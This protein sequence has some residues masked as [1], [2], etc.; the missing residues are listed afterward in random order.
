LRPLLFFKDALPAADEG[1]MAIDTASLTDE[2]RVPLSSR[3]VSLSTAAWLV[4]LIALSAVLRAIAAFSHATPRYFPDEYIY[5]SLARSLAHGQL[6]IRGTPARFPALLEPLLTAPLWLGDNVELSYRLT[7]CLHAGAA[8][9]AA[10][11]IY[12]LARRVSLPPWQSLVCSLL[13]LASP[14]LVYSSYLTADAL[15]LPLALAAVAAGVS[16]LSTPTRATQAWFVVFVTLACFARVQY[17]AVLAAFVVAAVVLAAGR[18]WTAARRL[19]LVGLLVAIPAVGIV[20]AGPGRALGYYDSILDLSIRPIAMAEWAGTD[21]ALLTY[22]AGWVLVPLA[23]VGLVGAAVRPST[24]QEQAFA[25]LAA[26]LFSFLLLEATLYAVNGSERFQERYLISLLP[27]VPVL[28]CLGARRLGSRR[29]SI[30]VALTAAGMLLLAVR[31]PLSGYTALNGKQ[32]SP[33]L[34]AVSQLEQRLGEGSAGLAIALAAGLLAL[35]AAAAA[36]FP[37]RTLALTLALALLTLTVSSIGAVGY[38]L[39]RSRLA[40]ETFVGADARWIDRYGLDRVAGV[41]T[42]G[43]L[44]PA[45][46]ERLFWNRSLSQLLLLP[47]ADAPDAFGS[48]A[49]RIRRDG[50]LFVNDREVRAAGLL[51]DEY[52]GPVELEGAVM[53]QRTAG[54]SLWRADGKPRL[55][56]MFSGRYLDG[57]LEPMSRLT[58]WPRGDRPRRG[59]LQLRFRL[60]AVAPPQ[61][62]ELRAPG[63]RRSLA[64]EP[65]EARSISLPVEARRP[66]RL[67]ILPRRQFILEGGRFVG[68]MIDPPTF[69]ERAPEST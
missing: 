62:L 32:D 25:V 23:V 41:L 36:A 39:E 31:M 59:T 22:A 42:A 51:F 66:W 24:R 49:I 67:V 60:P 4:P 21:A 54:A 44:R 2:R 57:W 64:I 38:D 53:L 61:T 19:P 14:A 16:A 10:I 63:V 18:P 27:L 37:R 55:V 34:Q 69:V 1:R 3:T 45:V 46:S 56:L 50:A 43:S 12:I 6:E 15:A 29:A 52:S 5:S 28:A 47:G 17:L 13:T 26:S 65:G 35:V 8:S 58:I 9:L 7:Q 40:K 48:T 68:V 30:A 33:F 11:P 20:A